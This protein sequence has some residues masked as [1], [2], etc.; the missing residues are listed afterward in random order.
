MLKTLTLAA[1]LLA[2]WLN[3]PQPNAPRL[4]NGKID[5]S[6]KAPRT[7]DGMPDLSGVWQT[8]LETADVIASRSNNDAAKFI[9]PGDD[10]NTFSRYFFDMLSDF[11][12]DEAP[13]RPATVE[14]MRA[15]RARQ[16]GN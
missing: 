12:A 10:P 16:A 11:K 1:L 7:R 14:Y 2:Q 4:P 8:E 6:A 9:V 15:R 5:M 3:Y 13:M